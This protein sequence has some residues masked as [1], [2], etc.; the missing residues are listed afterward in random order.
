MFNIYEFVMI[1]YILIRSGISYLSSKINEK[2]LIFRELA[3]LIG[4]SGYATLFLIA[5][6][7]A[8]FYWCFKNIWDGR[9]KFWYIVARILMIAYQWKAFYILSILHKVTAKALPKTS[10]IKNLKV[11]A[12]RA[13]WHGSSPCLGVCTTFIS[14]FCDWE[15]LSYALYEPA[16][17][18]P[19]YCIVFY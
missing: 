1:C 18:L 4:K 8:W 12:F 6:T 9:W 3:P 16:H 10:F 15:A 7:E 14:Y 2:A 19:S 13:S 5:R 17:I 11:D